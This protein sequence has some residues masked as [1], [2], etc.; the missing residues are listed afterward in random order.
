MRFFFVVQVVLVLLVVQVGLLGVVFVLKKQ[1]KRFNVP[2]PTIDFDESHVD[3]G[4]GPVGSSDVPESDDDIFSVPKWFQEKVVRDYSEKFKHMQYSAAAAGVPSWAAMPLTQLGPLLTTSPATAARK[5]PPTD[6]ADRDA[7]MRLDFQ[8]WEDRETAAR[9]KAHGLP[10]ALRN[11]SGLGA[12]VRLWSHAYL[13]RQLG[14]SL[15]LTV[16][17]SASPLFTYYSLK[18]RVDGL[19][20]E[21]L[22]WSPPQVEV[23]MSYPA[24][25][26]HVAATTHYP[27][28]GEPVPRPAHWLYLTL[29]AHTGAQTAW[30]MAG[31]PFFDEALPLSA[32]DPTR[33]IRSPPPPAAVAEKAR[34]SGLRVGAD[35]L[36]KGVNCRFAQQGVTAA[37]H[38][39]SHDNWVALVRGK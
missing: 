36:F 5:R 13:E 3:V 12:T 25:A 32:G 16:E 19:G 37:A 15:L 22:S 2:V 23:P 28:D 10:F 31:F 30:V 21:L 18:G 11:V 39:D 27:R 4:H 24:F 29:P 26:A 34:G 6:N 38:Y 20:L 7:L 1:I 8:S 35:K 14:A 9:R 33:L 17:R